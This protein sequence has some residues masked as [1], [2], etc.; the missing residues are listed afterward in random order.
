M[1]SHAPWSVSFPIRNLCACFLLF[2]TSYQLP[3][4]VPTPLDRNGSSSTGICGYVHVRSNDQR[5]HHRVSGAGC[6]QSNASYSRSQSSSVFKTTCCTW[7]NS[8]YWTFSLERAQVD[9][10]VKAVWPKS[11]PDL[12]SW[13]RG[14]LAFLLKKT[15]RKN[16]LLVS[17]AIRLCHKEVG[18]IS[19]A[20]NFKKTGQAT[21]QWQDWLASQGDSEP[22]TAK[23]IPE[24]LSES[25]LRFFIEHIIRT[26]HS[27][28]TGTW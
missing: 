1:C 7:G 15:F 11:S 26:T 18:H 21:N 25:F 19:R 9:E 13:G 6:Y 10:K 2:Y 27:T 24:Y 5:F 23:L 12:K 16:F 4:F 20:G 8:F 22:V 3:N 28:N 17:Q 14:L